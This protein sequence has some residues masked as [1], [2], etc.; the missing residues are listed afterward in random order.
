M[1][2]PASSCDKKVIDLPSLL[3]VS[4][5]LAPKNVNDLHA[6]PA[7]YVTCAVTCPAVIVPLLEVVF[8]VSPGHTLPAKVNV[9]VGPTTETEPAAGVSVLISI[10][11]KPVGTLPV[12]TAS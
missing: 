5:A 4:A 6:E 2:A 11:S 7:T 8:S 1:C 12:S 9:D 3:L 10:A